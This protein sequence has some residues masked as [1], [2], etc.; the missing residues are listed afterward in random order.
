MILKLI[1]SKL[2]EKKRITKILNYVLDIFK[3][4]YSNN[5]Y[6]IKIF[7]FFNFIFV[8]FDYM[9]QMFLFKIKKNTYLLKLFYNNK[10][11]IVL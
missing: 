2:K 11:L 8:K 5:I 7:L 3:K 1:N 4:Y 6:I 9:T 10:L